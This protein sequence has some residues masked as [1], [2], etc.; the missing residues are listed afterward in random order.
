MSS[1]DRKYFH[2]LYRSASDPWDF[3]ASAY[4]QRKYSLTLAALPR[5]RYTNAFE[6]GCSIGVLSARLATRCDRLLSTDIV[7]SVLDEARARLVDHSHVRVEQRAIPEEWPTELFD[8][9]VLSEVAYYFDPPALD[10]IVARVLETT[11]RNAH[12]VAV[13]WRGAT[14]YPLTA[15]EAHARIQRGDGLLRVV[16]HEEREF[17][18]DVWER[19]T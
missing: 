14:N 9:V 5:T 15:D 4:E 2:D 18:L 16:H 10:D 8:L 3:A 6:P 7:A 11:T 1:T 12:V 13:H 17:V 19:T